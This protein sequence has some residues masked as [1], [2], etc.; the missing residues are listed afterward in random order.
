MKSRRLILF[1]FVMLLGVY[2]LLNSLSN[3]RLK[4]LYGADIVSLVAIGLCVGFGV[5][6]LVGAHRFKCAS[7]SNCAQRHPLQCKGAANEKGKR[8][9]LRSSRG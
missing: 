8:A 3:Q 9:G 5:G 1:L 7:K 6:L 4:A 2:P